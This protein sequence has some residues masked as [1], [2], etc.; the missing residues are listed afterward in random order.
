METER[1]MLAVEGT[2]F[3]SRSIITN[4]DLAFILDMVIKN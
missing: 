3:W 4:T 1:S 2:R